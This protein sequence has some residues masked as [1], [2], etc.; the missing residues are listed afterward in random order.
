MTFD[1]LM[2]TP[3]ELEK[4]DDKQLLE[5]FG[6]YIAFA[7]PSTSGPT[8]DAVSRTAKS[9]ASRQTVVRKGL[10]K[11]HK[12]ADAALAQELLELYTKKQT[13]PI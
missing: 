9:V 5:Y 4:L 2:A 8:E 3:E 12:S 6:P 7:R 1:Q 11:G 10:F 13:P